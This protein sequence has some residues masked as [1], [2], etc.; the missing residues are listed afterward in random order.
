MVQRTLRMLTLMM[1]CTSILQLS[2]VQ[3]L[4]CG[5]PPKVSNAI[6]NSI[7]LGKKSFN[8]EDVVVYQCG[9]GYHLV[10][11]SSDISIT[12]KEDSAGSTAAWTP[13][14]FACTMKM[15]NPPQSILN[16]DY[17]PNDNFPYGSTVTY[18][19]DKGYS[20]VQSTAKA[21]LTCMD[22][23]RW[24]KN[25]PDCELV[26]CPEPPQTPNGSFERRTRYDFST[27][28]RYSCDKSFTLI[29]RKNLVCT[30]T[31][32]WDGNAPECK[33]VSCPFVD[34]EHGNLYSRFKPTYG[35]REKVKYECHENY[36]FEKES[37]ME[38]QADGTWSTL[39]VCIE[40]MCSSIQPITYGDHHPHHLN[41]VPNGTTVTF[42]CNSGYNMIGNAHLT[43][44]EG[45]WDK[46]TPYC[47]AQFSAVPIAVGIVA[48]IVLGLAA[49]IGVFVFLK[50]RRKQGKN[51]PAVVVPLH[52]Q[53]KD[54]SPFIEEGKVVEK[55]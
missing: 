1:V 19:C 25:A 22:D 33:V 45:Q 14:Q 43:C 42:S 18:S 47:E 39:P 55:V 21:T 10:D 11:R 6:L 35:Y 48:S 50:K 26:Q 51:E 27:S 12:C 40:N 37:F 28:I 53:E 41:K 9:L 16:G 32:E 7:H 54:T 3:A 30:F 17:Q 15:C 38:C 8:L 13:V 5:E 4:S 31:G 36:M 49:A 29:G 34:I 20:L 44:L 46:K 52:P 2:P 24:N 23:G